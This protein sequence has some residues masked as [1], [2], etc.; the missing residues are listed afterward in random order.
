[1]MRGGGAGRAALL[2]LR[3]VVM[4]GVCAK[5]DAIFWMRDFFPYAPG[6]RRSSPVADLVADPRLRGAASEVG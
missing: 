6:R 4:L 2:P 1:M 5:G 3:C